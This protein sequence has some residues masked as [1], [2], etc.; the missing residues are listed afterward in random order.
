MRRK[1]LIIALLFLC[2]SST[3]L[4]HPGGTDSNGGHYNRSTGEYHYHHGYSAHQHPGGVCPYDNKDNTKSKI[5]SSFSAFSALFAATPRPTSRPTYKPS[6]G[7]SST[8]HTGSSSYSITSHSG[9][10]SYSG[11]SRSSSSTHS[12]ASAPAASRALSSTSEAPDMLLFVFIGA[13]IALF[14]YH[15]KV[16][17]LQKDLDATRSKLYQEKD[18]S[19][20]LVSRLPSTHHPSSKEASLKQELDHANALLS[21]TASRC[22]NLESQLGKKN[23]ELKKATDSVRKLEA[24]VANLKKRCDRRAYYESHSLRDLSGMPDDTEIGADG[25]PKEKNREGWGPKYTRYVYSANSEKYHSADCQYAVKPVHV[26]D[27]S[28]PQRRCFY[29]HPDVLPDRTWFDRYNDLSYYYKKHGYIPLPDN[30]IKFS[31]TPSASDPPVTNSD[32]SPDHHP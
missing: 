6:T 1:S 9:T 15:L 11:S 18:Y 5:P 10:S 12:S 29:C 23:H 21:S 26:F 31:L 19:D 27:T 30:I 7:Y 22:S 17:S 24:Q 13:L 14:F 28:L 20:S 2:F 4:A 3:A 8:S 16:R 32:K 25:W